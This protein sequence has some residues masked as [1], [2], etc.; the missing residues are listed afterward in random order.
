[1]T[2]FSWRR[3][4]RSPPRSARH[5]RRHFARLGEDA[6]RARYQPCDRRDLKLELYPA[7]GQI[8]NIMFAGVAGPDEQFAGQNVYCER[9]SRWLHSSFVPEQDLEF[10]D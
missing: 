3:P 9:D 4:R 2:W 7:I 6:G 1:V 10:L 5:P 8:V